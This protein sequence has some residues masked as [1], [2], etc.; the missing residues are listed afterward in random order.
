MVDDDFPS[1]DA[2]KE[3]DAATP[4]GLS[5]REAA[6]QARIAEL[7]MR[8]LDLTNSNRLLNYKFSDRSRRQ[9]RLVDELPDELI[10][11]LADG[12]RLVFRPLPEL[13]D[14]PQDERE[15]DTFLLALEQAKR[16]DEEYLA[17]LETLGSDEEGEGARRAERALRD[18]L[19]KALGMPDRLLRDPISKAVW[20][21]QNNIEPS[22]DLP[23]LHPRKESKEEHLDVFMQTL[24]LPDEMERLLS[25][26]Y[27][28]TRTTLQETGVNT[29]YLAVGYLEWYEAPDSHTP[30]YAPLLLHPVD[31]ERKIVNGTYRYSIGSEETVMEINITL[32]G[33]L[34]KDFHRRL[35]PLDEIDTPEA[36]LRKVQAAI[37]DVPRWRVR[38]F[39]VIGHFSFARLLMFYDLEDGRWPGGKGV[40]GN[41]VI[42][43]LFAGHGT[44]ADAFSAE[45]YA[46]D[47]PAIAAKVPLLITDADSSQVSAIVDVMEGKNLAI[48]GPPG[49][50]KSQTI[51]N[52]IAA[53][54]A[55]EKTVL[56][57]A[58]KMAALNVVKHRLGECRT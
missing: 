19:R 22:F 51:T 48:K 38:R 56:F 26:I 40:L 16:S 17:A 3:G 55:A 29:L 44:A 50:G 42:A 14:E 9:V 41:S 52:I 37:A 11:R 35:P 31:I 6:A 24:L 28:Q 57:V 10:G 15:E 58:E 53:A 33:R 25:A 7:R 47:D 4:P 8:L 30:L 13:G 54:L 20:A 27:D 5:P 12:K 23:E 1:V 34:Y 43:D 18:R 46:V 36:Y 32:S 49:T 21:R 45:E 2:D 39:V